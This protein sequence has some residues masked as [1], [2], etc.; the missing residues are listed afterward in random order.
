MSRVFCLFQVWLFGVYDGCESG[1]RGNLWCGSGCV[2]WQCR[3]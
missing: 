1:D 2:S 3:K